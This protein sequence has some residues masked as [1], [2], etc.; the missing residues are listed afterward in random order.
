[1]SAHK[2]R[3]TL[4]DTYDLLS[5]VG[6]KFWASKIQLVLAQETFNF[7]TK[8]TIDSWYGG[9]GSFNDLIICRINGHKI[10]SKDESYIN[11]RLN[12]LRSNIHNLSKILS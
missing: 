10:E 2:L 7:S 11:N 8:S 5:A 1:M 6:E 4:S 3:R 9:M 12:F